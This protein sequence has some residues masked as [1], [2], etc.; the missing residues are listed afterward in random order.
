MYCHECG[1]FNE[2]GSLFCINCGARLL[3]EEESFSDDMISAD[4][5]NEDYSYQDG[6][7]EQPYYESQP[8]RD[9]GEAAQ[10]TSFAED[11]FYGAERSTPR[12][13]PRPTKKMVILCI[14][15]IAAIAAIGMFI[16]LKNSS[17]GADATAKRYFVDLCN[18]DYEGAFA[19][20]GLEETDF[21]NPESFRSYAASLDLGDVQNYTVSYNYANNLYE[22]QSSMGKT[23]PI[24]YRRTGESYDSEFYVNVVNSG[25]KEMLIF[26]DWYVGSDSL[27][28]SDYSLYVP[29][30]ASVTFDGVVLDA[31]TYATSQSDGTDLYLI[32]KLFAGQHTVSVSAAGRQTAT[33][34]LSVNYDQDT[35]YMTDLLYTEE[36][37]AVLE[38]IAVQYMS[39]LY[40][41][42]LAQSDFSVIE[43]HFVADANSRASIQ[44]AYESLV[45]Y[46]A[47]DAISVS[48]SNISTGGD[49][50]AA[51]IRIDFDYEVSYYKNAGTADSYSS[52]DTI[53]LSFTPENDIWVLTDLG[54]KSLY[55]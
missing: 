10:D 22:S 17:T 55:Y 43:D 4:P 8:G 30:G 13:K 2:D 11:P 6:E 54:A 19:E 46:F 24:L 40:Q 34:V 35:G 23:V 53:Y 48:F 21:I 27:L 42:A 12:V 3:N 26:D 37:M 15:I 49:T 36:Q 33:S 39:D 28:V 25:Q 5:K 16:H 1:T 7:F 32:P 29:Q 20:L 44:E 47:D 18:G 45:R 51:A 50:S 14:E 38:D 52:S 41:C 31:G 9:Y